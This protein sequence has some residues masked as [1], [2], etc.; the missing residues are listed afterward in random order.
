MDTGVERAPE[1]KLRLV[2]KIMAM[3]LKQGGRGRQTRHHDDDYFGEEGL[4]IDTYESRYA[5]DQY[6][7]EEEEE[8]PLKGGRPPVEELRGGDR[9]GGRGGRGGRGDR[10][11]DRRGGNNYGRGGYR[12]DR[13]NGYEDRGGRSKSRG[14]PRQKYPERD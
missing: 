1:D 4:D 13:G 9:R 8:V 2:E 5:G 14:A 7:S 3:K 10:G 11:G 12:G 6:E